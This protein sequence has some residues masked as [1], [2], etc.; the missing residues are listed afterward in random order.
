MK[1]KKQKSFMILLV[2]L[3]AVMTCVSCAAAKP[4]EIT[5]QN[6][7]G[8]PIYIAFAR[9]GFGNDKTT[10]G[11]YKLDYWE[12]KVLKLPFNYDADDYYY[13]YAFCAQPKKVVWSGKDFTGWIHPK[14]AFKSEQGRRVPG[15]KQ[16]GFRQLKVNKGGQA[17]IN[18]TIK[19]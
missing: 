14:D 15:G 4:V 6:Q 16:V 5:L 9:E 11:W 1:N 8:Y 7:A 10:R 13:F 12:T 17:R 18:F 19:N 3:L 2:C